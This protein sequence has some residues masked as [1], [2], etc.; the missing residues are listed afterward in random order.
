[1]C[2]CANCRYCTH[3]PNLFQQYYWCSWFGK[4]VRRNLKCDIYEIR[5]INNTSSYCASK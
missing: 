5:Q 1:M 4:E 2:I 3:P